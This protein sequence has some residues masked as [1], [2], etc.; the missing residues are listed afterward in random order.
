LEVDLGGDTVFAKDVMAALN[1]LLKA[2][3]L[4]QAAQILEPDGCIG[5]PAQNSSKDLV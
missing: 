3:A 2:Q 5:C 1:T 4:Q